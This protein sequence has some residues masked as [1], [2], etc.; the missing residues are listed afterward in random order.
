MGQK[1]KSILV[2]DDE[3][4]A[5]FGLSKLLSQEGYEVHGVANGYEALDFLRRR[6]VNL[7]ITDINMPEMNGL[8]FLRELNRHHPSTHVI[9]ITAYGG[10]ESYL[11]AM[12][13]GAFEYIHKPVK[14]DELKS[15]MQKIFGDSAPARLA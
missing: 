12:N 11:E 3:E 10:V 1:S 7:V 4:N 14:L 13:L 6:E 2:V 9:M 8:A 15:V 5:R